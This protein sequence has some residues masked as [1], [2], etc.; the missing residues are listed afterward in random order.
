MLYCL[1]FWRAPRW[2]LGKNVNPMVLSTCGPNLVLLE[3][4]EPNSPFIALTI[5]NFGLK[6]F[7]L[8]KKLKQFLEPTS[9]EQWKTTNSVL[10]K[11]GK[12]C[13]WK[14]SNSHL[15]KK[16]ALFKKPSELITHNHS[17]ISTC[18]LIYMCMY[19]LQ[20]LFRTSKFRETSYHLPK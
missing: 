11:N 5:I 13:H 8:L 4:S 17:A 19:T 20:H 2:M 14:D 9:A 15:V 12:I 18:F 1:D 3:E 16:S 7:W 10:L 6:Q